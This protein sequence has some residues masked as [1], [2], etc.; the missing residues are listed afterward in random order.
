M[1]SH[2]GG[3]VYENIKIIEEGSGRQGMREVVNRQIRQ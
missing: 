2:Q 3:H 1:N